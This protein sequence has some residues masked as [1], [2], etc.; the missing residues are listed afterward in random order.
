[1]K[2]KFINQWESYLEKSDAQNT[3]E[4]TMNKKKKIEEKCF[5]EDLDDSDDEDNSTQNFSLIEEINSYLNDNTY[6]SKDILSFWENN[7]LKYRI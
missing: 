5:L 3:N 7:S 2:K 1:M 6:Y 4:S